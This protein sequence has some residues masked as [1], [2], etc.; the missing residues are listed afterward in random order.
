[1]QSEYCRL[2]ATLT[3]HLTTMAA[4]ACT[5]PGKLLPSSSSFAAA[6]CY[7]VLNGEFEVACVRTYTV[8]CMVQF[9]IDTRAERYMHVMSESSC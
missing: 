4:V 6:S 2:T 9:D 3:Q 1:V 8:G 5:Q 7:F